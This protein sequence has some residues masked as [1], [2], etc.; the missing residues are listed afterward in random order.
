MRNGKS[1]V[2]DAVPGGV[3]GEEFTFDLQ[4]FGDGQDDI[5]PIQ[6]EFI[7]AEGGVIVNGEAA[8]TG[9]SLALEGRGTGFDLVETE[10]RDQESKKT[11]GAEFEK[12]S[13][14]K[15]GWKVFHS[16]LKE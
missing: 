6:I 13:T 1:L 3:V 4:F 7:G 11:G 5:A 9:A 8:P 12:I 16:S 14:S 10:I 2:A 15:G